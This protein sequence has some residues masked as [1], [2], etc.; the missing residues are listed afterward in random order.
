M[1]RFG[2]TLAGAGVLVL[3]ALFGLAACAPAA[4]PTA[5]APAPTTAPAAA[6]TVAPGIGTTLPLATSAVPFPTLG[7]GPAIK[8][9]RVT[10]F[11]L[12]LTD[13]KD[14]TLY[15]F[16]KD[17]KD[18]S[19]CTGGCGTTWPPY[20]VSAK[21]QA[22]E[23]INATLISTFTRADGTIQGQYDTHPLYYYSN[24]KNPGDFK[25]HGIGGVWHVLSPRGSPM[26]NAAPTP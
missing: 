5:T 2:S 13:E 12:Y 14:R 24:D 16:D 7:P 26:T 25:G 21:P 15:A 3:V 1:K 4:A 18:T 10:G 17:S 6:P 19:T 23:G 8:L 11:G 22:A 9:A 20:I